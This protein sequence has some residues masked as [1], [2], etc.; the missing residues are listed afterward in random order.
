MGIFDPEMITIDAADAPIG[1]P[2]DALPALAA[3]FADIGV[4]P[5]WLRKE[6]PRFILRIE[7]YRIARYPVSRGDWLAYLTIAGDAATAGAADGDT[8]RADHPA[9]V[10]HAGAVAYAEWLSLQTGRSFRLPTEFEW[11]YA[12]AGPDSHAYPWGMDYRPGLANTAEEDVGDT[13][14]AGKRLTNTAWCGAVDMAGNAEEWTASRYRPYPG[15]E[16]IHDG[17][18]PD[19]APYVVTRGGS[20]RLSRDCARC[21][22]R[23]GALGDAVVGLRLAETP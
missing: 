17:F 3:D 22:R 19:G 1:T 23:H 13:V 11:E 4:E 5:E 2:F 6:C 15:G 14:P 8:G 9:A 12:A 20:W 21:Q 7:R 10:S 18:N 16:A